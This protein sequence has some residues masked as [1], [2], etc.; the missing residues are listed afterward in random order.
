M[1]LNEKR[2]KSILFSLIIIQFVIREWK[3][4]FD[5]VD[6][7]E[8]DTLTYHFKN[9]FIF[10]PD[11][12]GQGLTGN[13]IITMPHALLSGLLLT[14]NIDK[15]PML[16]LITKSVDRIFQNPVDIFWQGRVMDILFDGIPVD[17]SSDSFE[18]QAVC[19]VF[20]TG[21]VKAVKPL[22]DTHYKFSLFASVCFSTLNSFQSTILNF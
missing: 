15:K 17:C 4:K 11:L 20:S 8:D 10:R 9:T 16:P 13:E 1:L 19:S 6:D 3:E 7:E 14:I 22:N 5:M 21:D 18:A 12:S 2:L